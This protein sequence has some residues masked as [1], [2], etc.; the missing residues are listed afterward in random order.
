M[1]SENIA[2]LTAQNFDSTIATKDIPIL[3][4]FWAPW[5]GPC[6]AIAPVLEELA[7]EMGS[8][9]RICKVNVDENQEIA[10]KYSIRAIPTILLF[11]DGAMV[12]Q[13]VGLTNKADLSAKLQKLIN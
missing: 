2:N 7:T 11:K 9:V 13:V 3:V 1:S 4:D 5:C 8:K 12:E 6:R 10:A